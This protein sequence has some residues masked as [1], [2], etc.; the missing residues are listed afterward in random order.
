M[1]GWTGHAE[2]PHLNRLPKGDYFVLIA[3][4]GGLDEMREMAKKPTYLIYTL[5]IKYHAG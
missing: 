5:Y 1:D 2:R 3:L 4:H